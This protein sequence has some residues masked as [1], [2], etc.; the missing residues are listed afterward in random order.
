MPNEI[1]F[2]TLL[3]VIES[4]WQLEG[5]AGRFKTGTGIVTTVDRNADRWRASLKIQNVQGAGRA[6]LQRLI[7]SMHGG[8]N[9]V[10]VHDHSY[11]QRGSFPSDEIHPNPRMDGTT[12]YYPGSNGT[13]TETD[14]RLRAAVNY[15][16]GGATSFFYLLSNG[17]A[18]ELYYPYLV[19]VMVELG[20]PRIATATF[21]LEFGHTTYQGQYDMDGP[22]A[23]PHLFRAAGVPYE[24]TA[25]GNLQLNASGGYIGG[26]YIYSPFVSIS[27]CALVDTAPNLLKY[28][29]DLSG[30]GWIL[31]ATSY[32]LNATIGPD[33]YTYADKLIE[34]NTYTSHYAYQ[35][36]TVASTVDI[37]FVGSV[38]CK[39]AERTW[40]CIM[41]RETTGSTSAYAYFNLSTG[42]IGTV[43][44]VTSPN[45][46][47]PRAYI[48]SEGGGWYRCSI[49]AKKT[50]SATGVHC[51]TYIATGDG[52]ATYTG[53]GSSGIYVDHV[54]LDQS[55]V[56]VR[57]TATGSA[58][59]TGT[60]PS[61]NELW[62]K[63]L[64]E[65][66]TGLLLPGDQFQIGDELK[67]VTAALN[68]DG[69]GLGA[70]RFDPPLRATPAADDPVIINTPMTKMMLADRSNS[71]RSRPGGNG[72]L[73]DAVIELIEDTR[74]S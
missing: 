50:N 23:G 36:A 41:L 60:D 51:R 54:S 17:F 69:L 20:S 19:R 28:S 2:P 62:V 34:D 72:A 7:A 30:S 16:P 32:S 37:E 15:N 49:V 42:V 45:W 14:R 63:G 59:D 38:S 68:S 6:A 1:L 18:P 4:E 61:G 29:N 35:N 5:N 74:T 64:P 46:S 33:G 58:A 48:T 40:C 31:G 9:S 26:D 71:W 47:H 8:V 24:A 27:R 66:E 55:A 12:N 13:M 43:A 73:S 21:T 39:A 70:L 65:S 25:Y 67:V 22:T 52:T 3:N 11:T 57:Y 44:M 53:D 10:W 56:P